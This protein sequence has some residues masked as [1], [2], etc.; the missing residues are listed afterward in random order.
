MTTPPPPTEGEDCF[1]VLD[2]ANELNVMTFVG[3]DSST[4]ADEDKP[5]Q[6]FVDTDGR[7]WLRI[8]EYAYHP[9]DGV[10]P[11]IARIFKADSTFE[12]DAVSEAGDSGLS[13]SAWTL[14]CSR[15]CEGWDDTDQTCCDPVCDSWFD[16][17][18]AGV[19]AT[20][21]R[22]QLACCEGTI[23]VCNPPLATCPKETCSFCP[24]NEVAG[25]VVVD[26][27]FTSGCSGCPD[28]NGSYVL[29]F[30][31]EESSKCKYEEC[32]E[33]AA[34]LCGLTPAGIKLTVFIWGTGTAITV[35]CRVSYVTTT[36]CSASFGTDLY[37]GGVT[38]ISGLT[39][40]GLGVVSLAH[41][42]STGTFTPPWCG[43]TITVE[44][45]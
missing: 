44:P 5:I 33:L 1:P 16:F 6:L 14:V 9:T 12:C 30:V 41:S 13:V 39:C 36:G 21:Y 38:A 43:G 24:D 17:D 19:A 20:L 42:S 34:D 15:Q 25:Y 27:D 10:K 40:D 28:W 22:R 23:D 11:Y 7:L 37:T 4:F 29:P 45:I 32:F 3:V 35:W 2:C 31:G 26:L 8:N 18:S